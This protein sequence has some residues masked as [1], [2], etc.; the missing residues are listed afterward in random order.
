[1]NR[2]YLYGLA[3]ASEMYRIV[4]HMYID[5]EKYG[6]DTRVEKEEARNMAWKNPSIKRVYA[7]SMRPGLARD[8]T[9]A[10]TKNSIESYNIFKDILEREGHPVNI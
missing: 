2:V 4:S 10:W 1:M 6:Y 9:E 3:G 7:I 5:T 8:Y